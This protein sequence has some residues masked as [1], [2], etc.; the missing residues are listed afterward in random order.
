MDLITLKSIL[1][2]I[3]IYLFW[4]EPLEK[5]LTL[6][7]E[8]AVS[9]VIIVDEGITPVGILTEHDALR[10]ASDA[11]DLQTSLE[12]VMTP[13]PFCVKESLSIHEA[14]ALM[15]E[16]AYKHL[17]VVDD[18]SKF[19]GIV[20]EGD[21]LRHIGFDNLNQMKTVCDVMNKNPLQIQADSSIREIASMM[22]KNSCD[23]AVV[24][25]ESTIKGLIT[26][27]D[28]SRLL[29]NNI[30]ISEEQFDTILQ[31]N[32]QSVDKDTL[33]HEAASRMQEHNVHQLIVVDELNHLVGLLSR[34]DILHAIHGAYFEFLF[35]VINQ[36]NEAITEL[37]ERKKRLRQE[38]EII[39]HN[40]IKYMKLFE[41]I[42]DGVLLIETLNWKAVEFNKAAHEQLGYSASEFANLTVFDY[43]IDETNENMTRI[44]KEIAESGFMSFE[45]IHRKKDAKELNVFVNLTTI[46]LDESIYIMGVFQDITAK[47]RAQESLMARQGELL[48]QK[49]FLNTL[50]NTIPDMIWFKN[51][52]GVYLAC[53]KMFERFFNATEAEIVSKTDFDFVNTKLANFF[54]EHDR[55]T[56]END[57][58]HINEE[59]IQFRD[60]SYEGCFETLKTPMKDV[61]GNLLGVLGIYRDISERKLKDKLLSNIQSLA[62][63]GTWEWD[64]ANDIFFGTDESY[65]IFGIEIGKK[66]SLSELLEYFVPEEHEKLKNQLFN[67]SKEMQ[68]LGSLYKIMRSNGEFRWI[69][70]HTE[71]LYDKEN[72][73]FKAVG[74]FQDVTEQVEHEN[75]MIRKD[76]DLNEAQKLVVGD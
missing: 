59:F 60:G 5:A 63:I 66:I 10:I 9:S 40:N 13:N 36:K 25:R 75:E 76:A 7:N 37:H 30:E 32:F 11:I 19:I 70:T 17:V 58:P 49:S 74:M 24:M 29:T 14:Y 42:P 55:L 8:S 44:V 41:A 43:A 35:E 46:T 56:I 12:K 38:K 22:N 61:D 62:R 47:K 2:D 27:R 54:R 3:S 73:P 1:S 45:T 57:T 20:S 31:K 69:R 21:F 72:Q 23:Y 53:N 51:T 68:T 48:E 4:H 18:D 15:E 33:L 52:K 6:M 34:H 50:V 39:V 28:I 64:I 71:F 67:A 26:E 65:R 16:K